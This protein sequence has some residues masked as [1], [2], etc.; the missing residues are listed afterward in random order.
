VET[1]KNYFIF[2]L[3]SAVLFSV[4]A[5]EE[6]IEKCDNCPTLPWLIIRPSLAE[7]K[8]IVEMSPSANQ[9]KVT[10]T[11]A[12]IKRLS[13]VERKYGDE[14]AIGA[15]LEGKT[16]ILKREVFFHKAIFWPKKTIADY[17]LKSENAN[18]LEKVA[19]KEYFSYEIFFFLLG[20][21]FIGIMAGLISEVEKNEIKFN[22]RIVVFLLAAAC[23]GL[24]SA[25]LCNDTSNYTSMI[26]WNPVINFLSSCFLWLCCSALSGIIL[27]ILSAISIGLIRDHA[28]PAS[29][30]GINLFFIAVAL[31]V[32]IVVTLSIAAL[33]ISWRTGDMSYWFSR[34]FMLGGSSM[35]LSMVV[36]WAIESL[37]KKRENA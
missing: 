37:I 14:A 30:A 17:F 32:F 20:I 36:A 5:E 7:P 23:L 10:T 6:K 12:V 22:I 15:T 25:P 33:F 31:I 3:L 11:Y 16:K 28:K 13:S 34:I 24:G 29:L 8:P 27:F 26:S 19:K 2:L 1:I 35:I 9:A 4:F 21:I 18:V